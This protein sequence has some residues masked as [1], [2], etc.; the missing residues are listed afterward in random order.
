[1]VVHH[2]EHLYF[3]CSAAIVVDPVSRHLFVGWLF[4]LLAI[5]EHEVEATA[6]AFIRALNS[7][8]VQIFASVRNLLYKV[9]F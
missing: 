9:G 4:S 5:T 6:F 8:K 3:L 7:S 1:V 2:R